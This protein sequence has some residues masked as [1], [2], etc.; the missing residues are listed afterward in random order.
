MNS[1][2]E[3]ISE[4]FQSQE[5]RTALKER[6]INGTARAGELE[7]ARGLGLIK[8]DEEQSLEYKAKLRALQARA[9]HEFTILNRLHR[10]LDGDDLSPSQAIED[11]T[12]HLVCGVVFTNGAQEQRPG[13]GLPTILDTPADT[14]P[15]DDLLPPK[16]RT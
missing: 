3:F 14:A 5:Y 11:P 2:E 16:R 12:T 7:I 4:V 1:A 10:R 13:Q 6:L 15:D 8:T 9:P